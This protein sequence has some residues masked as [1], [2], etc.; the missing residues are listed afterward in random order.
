MSNPSR[1]Y[2]H[3][4]ERSISFCVELVSDPCEEEGDN[5]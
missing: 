5:R 2:L 3:V 1:G 4:R